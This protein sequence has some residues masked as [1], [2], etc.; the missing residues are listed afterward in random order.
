N[1]A[2][3]VYTFDSSCHSSN[4]QGKCIDAAIAAERA[5]H[6][7]A[8]HDAR[9]SRFAGFMKCNPTVFH[10]TKGAI[11]LRRWFKKTESFLESVNV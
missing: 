8:G 6:A 4:D 9:E 7:D 11:E 10:S 5:R 1:H 3:K 2:S